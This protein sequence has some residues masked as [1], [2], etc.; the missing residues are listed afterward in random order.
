MTTLK[1]DKN[2]N[3][4]FANDFLTLEGQNAIIQDVKNLL[5]MFKTEYPF[6]LTMGLPWYDLASFN[7]KN[8]ISNAVS[9]RILEDSRINSIESLKVDFIQGK[10]NIEATIYTTEGIVN[11]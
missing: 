2:N 11:V 3:L 9:E 1:L 5:L 8:I 10:L 6:D 4:E 7:N